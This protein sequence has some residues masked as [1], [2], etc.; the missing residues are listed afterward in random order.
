MFYKDC[1]IIQAASLDKTALLED[2][3]NMNHTAY[4]EAYRRWFSRYETERR[5]Q[6]K[7]PGA[8]LPDFPPPPASPADISA[9][10]DRFGRFRFLQIIGA[11][12]STLARWE[13][14]AAVMPRAYWLL[15]TM[16][17][18]GRLPGMSAD[19]SDFRFEDDRLCLIGTRISYTARE[20]AGWQYQVALI[21]SLYG[22]IGELERRLEHLMAI[23]DFG[24]S[25]RAFFTA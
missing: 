7:R 4:S 25:N 21:E 8:E 3:N 16:L 23:G 2:K 17:D 20:I 10:L 11:H 19:W 22:R 24:A 18:R 5:R 9:A 6:K 14:G 15:L 13:S 12:R 1:P